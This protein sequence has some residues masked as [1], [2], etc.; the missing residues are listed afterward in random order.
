MNAN[1]QFIRINELYQYDSR[2]VHELNDLNQRVNVFRTLVRQLSPESLERLRE[3][4]RLKNIYNSNAI[5]GN[6]LSMGETQLVVREGIT[7]SGKPLRDTLEAKNLSNALDALEALAST[8]ENPITLQ[9]VRN[10]HKLVLSGIDDR[11]AGK[12]R[13]L[14]V[15][16]TGAAFPTPDWPDVPE[17]MNKFGQWLETVTDKARLDAGLISENPLVLACTAHTWF[18]YIHPFVDGN[19]RS[20]RILMNLM[21]IRAGYPIAI[22]TKDDRQRYYDALQESDASDLTPF[23][24]L[25]MESVLESIEVYEQAAQG[26]IS[27]AA[28]A[29]TL[30]ASNQA[31]VRNEYDVFDSAMRLLRG[32][33]QQ[34]VQVVNERFIQ[35]QMSVRVKLKDFGSLEL[36][37]YQSL[38]EAQSAKLTWYFRV[39]VA[40]ERSKA[41]VKRYMFFWGYAST[42]MSN[43]VG[44]KA[45]TLHIAAETDPFH[46]VK[47]RDTKFPASNVPAIV[48]I[49]YMP[50]EETFVYMDRSLGFH[51]VRAEEIAKEFVEQAITKFMG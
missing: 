33:F 50:A 21:L 13:E 49:G 47:L 42:P 24:R 20:A 40:D 44:K 37:K 11:N 27:M 46:Y 12:F 17:M 2:I 26:Q 41:N 38:R 16:I 14:P 10:L 15:Q 34:V 5:E 31:R 48:E 4:F 19:G 51:K 36:E 29:D 35:E 9:D 6:S 22:I 30:V 39:D 23:I 7:I 18:V 45:V 1:A 32:Y 3:Y 8:P 25:V 28:L 43:V